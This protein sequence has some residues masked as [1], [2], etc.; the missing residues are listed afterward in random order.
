MPEWLV[1]KKVMIAYVGEDIEKE[2]HSFTAGESAN[3]YSH[4]DVTVHQ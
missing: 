2:E 3:L 4:F 1:S